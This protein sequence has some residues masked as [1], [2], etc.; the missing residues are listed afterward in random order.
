M[1]LVLKQKKRIF[2]YWKL[3]CKKLIKN[4]VLQFVK[5][6]SNIRAYM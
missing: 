4:A 5:I 1:R 3:L 2:M 6:K